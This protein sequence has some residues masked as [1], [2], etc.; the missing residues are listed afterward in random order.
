MSMHT[1]IETA[2]LERA[3]L[4]TM[5][6]LTCIDFTHHSFMDAEVA[7][8]K[9]KALRFA[10]TNHEIPSIMRATSSY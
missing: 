1:L 10:S 9:V 2:L 8:T 5:N 3:F 4:S 7:L 6:I